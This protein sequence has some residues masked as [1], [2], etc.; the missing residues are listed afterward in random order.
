MTSSTDRAPPSQ[1]R[2]DRFDAKQSTS[3]AWASRN[4]VGRDGNLLSNQQAMQRRVLQDV[5]AASH[6][7]AVELHKLL[8]DAAKIT[9]MTYRCKISRHILPCINSKDIRQAWMQDG[10]EA[11]LQRLAWMFYYY[12]TEI[13][14]LGNSNLTHGEWV[15]QKVMA[16]LNVTYIHLKQLP[17]GQRTCVHQLYSRKFNDFRNNIMRRNSGFQHTSMVNKEQPKLSGLFKKNF[18]RGKSIFFATYDVREKT[19]WKKVS[20]QNRKEINQKCALLIKC[21]IRK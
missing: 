5:K 8:H 6:I 13:H 19:E 14:K 16:S 10:G 17:I 18:K 20:C 15:E 2:W 9:G 21:K 11:N 3:L 7:I 4:C 12:G 1:W